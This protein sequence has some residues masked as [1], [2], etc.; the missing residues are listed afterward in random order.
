LSTSHKFSLKYNV[1]VYNSTLDER[2]LLF[3]NIDGIYVIK[4]KLTKHI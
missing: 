4:L 3:D 2:Y 1:L